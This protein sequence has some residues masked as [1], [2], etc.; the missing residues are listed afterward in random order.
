M[1]GNKYIYIFCTLF[2]Y[3]I[4]DHQWSVTVFVWSIGHRFLNSV[5]ICGRI[6]CIPP[7]QKRERVPGKGHRLIGMA[8]RFVGTNNTGGHFG[9]RYQVG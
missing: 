5:V 8:Q 6:L 3:I 4:T 2:V 7:W 1:C 9:T